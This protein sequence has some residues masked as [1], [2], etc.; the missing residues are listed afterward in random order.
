I[1]K[2]NGVYGAVFLAMLCPLTVGTLEGQSDY[3]DIY[4]TDGIDPSHGVLVAAKTAL[5]VFKPVQRN[6][7][8]GLPR[9][10]C[11]GLIQY[12]EELFAIRRKIVISH[13]TRGN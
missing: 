5:D 7:H 8:L 4:V 6:A 13:R 1:R 11:V 9:I 3:M 10:G 2:A 12:D